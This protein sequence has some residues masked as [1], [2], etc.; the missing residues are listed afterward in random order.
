MKEKRRLK[1]PFPFCSCSYLKVTLNLLSV[2]GS[3]LNHLKVVNKSAL[4]DDGPV[5][6]DLSHA[7]LLQCLDNLLVH[8]HLV[9]QHV[10]FA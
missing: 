7:K 2:L 4:G 5:A 8:A 9:R 1:R 10:L 3:D 6:H